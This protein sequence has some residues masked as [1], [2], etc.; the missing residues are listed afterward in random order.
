MCNLK[1]Y[2]NRARITQAQLAARVGATQS[3][4]SHYELGRRR[5]GLASC[6]MLLAALGDLGVECTLDE[7]F[8]PVAA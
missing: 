6:R 7:V 2:R 1:N 3:A 8:P 4:I 5:P